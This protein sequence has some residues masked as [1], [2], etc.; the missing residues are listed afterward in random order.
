MYLLEF[1]V[2]NCLWYFTSQKMCNWKINLGIWWNKS[3]FLCSKKFL[4]VVLLLW[5]DCVTWFWGSALKFESSQEDRW[6]LARWWMD[7]CCHGSGRSVYVCRKSLKGNLDSVKKESPI[8]YQN[9]LE[10]SILKGDRPKCSGIWRFQVPVWWVKYKRKERRRWVKE[11]LFL[12]SGE[13]EWS[14]ELTRKGH[15]WSQ[16]S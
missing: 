10:I 3:P 9:V 4:V 14:K 12:T 5:E 7:L 6:Q 8:Y 16:I 11:D 15:F 1:C 2:W 13:V